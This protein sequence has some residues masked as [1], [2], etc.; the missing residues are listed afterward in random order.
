MSESQLVYRIIHALTS[1]G[2]YVRKIHGGPYQQ[3]GLPD[4]WCC[5]A[6]RLVCFEVKV[7]PNRT[8]PIQ[9]I[10]L[11]HLRDAG[12]IACVA[13]SVEEVIELVREITEEKQ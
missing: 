13:T 12:A 6:G 2:I 7:P 10:E 1:R 4:L 9:D 11:Q 8:T 3:A 5:V